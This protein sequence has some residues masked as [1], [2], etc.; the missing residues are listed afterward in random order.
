M[1]GLSAA[2]LIHGLN[3]VADAMDKNRDALCKLD[4]EIGDA[5][6]GVAM[7]GGFGAVRTALADLEDAA[8]PTDVLNTS[9][10][11]FLNAV[12]ASSGP[13]YATA[14]MRGAMAVKG[15]DRISDGDVPTWIAAMAEGIAHR[16]KASLGDKTMLD[17]WIPAA[18]AAQSASGQRASAVLEAAADA[19]EAGAEA[20]RDL[21]AKLGRAAR[22]GE[23][24]VGHVDP[25]AASAAI[26]LRALAD[27]LA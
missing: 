3:A 5:D 13:L 21:Q 14:M 2:D 25:G 17:A 6:H 8:T 9:A 24:S 20:T 10:K 4:G 22:L 11:A 19:A 15:K 18:E 7:A 23:R 27:S 26:V 12:G 1:A 16:G